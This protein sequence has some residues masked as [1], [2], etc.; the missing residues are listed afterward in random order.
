M[1]EKRDSNEPQVETPSYN[2]PNS[3][4][5]IFMGLLLLVGWIV[6]GP[7]ATVHNDQTYGNEVSRGDK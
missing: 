3:K 7:G 2:G 5:I 6:F 1:K 4:T